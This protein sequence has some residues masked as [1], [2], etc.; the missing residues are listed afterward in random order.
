MAL[1]NQTI[2]SLH[3]GV[4]N[5][6]IELRREDQVEEMINAIPTLS[7]GTRRRNPTRRL[8]NNVTHVDNQWLYV[9]DRGLTGSNTEQY[10]ITIANNSNEIKVMDK[11]GV[12]MIVNYDTDTQNYLLPNN[13]ARSFSAITIKD[14]TIILNK[15]KKVLKKTSF[16]QDN[17]WRAK[18]YVWVQ[19]VDYN[20]PVTTTLELDGTIVTATYPTNT[21]STEV[22]AENIKDAVNAVA[23]YTATVQ[24]SIV[25]IVK[26][27]GT[28]IIFKYSDTI[29][30]SAGS[31]WAKEVQLMSDLPLDL[32]YDGAV[33]KVLN[34]AS[35]DEDDFYV[36]FE[37]GNWIE[38][39][40]Q[41]EQSGFDNTTMPVEL[42]RESNG[43]FTLKFREY[44]D[45]TKGDDTTSPDPSFVDNYIKDLFFMK[46]RLGFITSTD[47]SMSE[48]GEYGNFY[49]TTT[50][51]LLDSDPIDFTVDSNE[52]VN[53]E[54][55]T[56]LQTSL[57]VFSDKHQFKIDGG[58][59]L[60][61][62]S[63]QAKV[64]TRYNTDMNCRPLSLS[65]KVFFVS[66]GE[67]YSS[68]IEYVKN[69]STENV[70]GQVITA[71]IPQYIPNNIKTICGSS[72]ENM[73]FLLPEPREDEYND[74]IYVY[75]YYYEG[76]K[77]LQS[78]WFKWKIDGN[79]FAIESLDDKLLIMCKRFPFGNT[80]LW[81]DE[82]LWEDNSLW[83]EN[84]Y[85]DT[86]ETISLD[87]IEITEDFRD[88]ID[89]DGDDTDAQKFNTEIVLSEWMLSS[90][91][92]KIING[93]QHF[94]TIEISSAKDSEYTLKIN[95][96]NRNKSRELLSKYVVNRKPFVGGKSSDVE[97]SIISDT[98][99][100]FQ[101]GSLSYEGRFNS[102]G[103]TIK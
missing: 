12:D 32:K 43:E 67:K 66:K 35:V 10:I 47:I 25:E 39:I 85:F 89:V 99:K 2:Q 102:R 1:I 23:G 22:A 87:P 74:T 101:L 41:N 61:P 86:I 7:L 5:Q 36:K 68:V 64:A 100:G 93:H 78:A 82:T 3:G 80:E 14:T 21:S 8:K 75:R 18:A 26:D 62:K 56:F 103:K 45:R 53:L 24:G 60:A 50:L 76:N 88:N 6:N 90:K 16:T 17:T 52:A 97:I 57:I 19:R 4:S 29:G 71:H 38:T 30:D 63:V 42:V 54:Y 37:D 51:S 31:G 11:D 9:Y 95:H 73:L 49:R 58:D 20:F 13:G 44:S 46:N 48:A 72:K 28:E 70:D 84:I 83:T 33:V 94:Q 96:T 40:N 92:K 91:G 81:E 55:A 27:D 34:S 69:T 79:I 59:I 15:D 98:S 77:L 65:N